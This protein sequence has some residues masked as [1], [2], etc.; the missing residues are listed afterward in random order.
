[1]DERER[2]EGDE[3]KPEKKE[4]PKEGYKKPELSNFGPVEEFTGDTPS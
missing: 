4:Q 1:M 3:K 2:V